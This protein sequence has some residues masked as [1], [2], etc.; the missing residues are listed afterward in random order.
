M[1]SALL[2]LGLGACDASPSSS[3]SPSPRA[4]TSAGPS[5]PD[6]SSAPGRTA[7]ARPTA[8]PLP[9]GTPALPAVPAVRSFHAAAGQ[10]WWPRPGTRVVAEDPAVEDEARL[11][12]AEIGATAVRG[13]ARDAREGDVRLVLSGPAEGAAREAYRLDSSGSRLVVTG[14][15]DT[16][17]FYGTRTAA[18]AL[19]ARG[20]LPSGVAEDRPD[21][22]QRGLM[23]DIARKHFSKEWLLDRVREMGDLKLN[24]LHLHISDDQGFRVESTSHPEVVSPRH[25]S[26]RDVSEIVAYA[27]ARHIT[28]IPEIDSPGHLGAVLR[29][30]PELQLRGNTGNR[31]EG[32]V[33]ISDPAA[34]RIIDD[35]F[36]EYAELFPGPYWHLGGDEYIALWSKNPEER[37]PQLAAWARER[38]GPDATVADAAT[39]WL[40]DRADVLRGLGRTVKAWNDGF[41]SSPLVSPHP[42]REVEYWTGREDGQR[43]PEEF[44]R[45]GWR[46]VNLNDEYLYY[47]LGEPN[48]FTYPT[49]ERI[50]REW[51]PA[52]LR[53]TTPVARSLSGPDRVLG[54]RL[55]VWCDRPGAQ[56]QAQVAQGIRMPLRALAQRVWDPEAPTLSWE[57]FTR[58]ADRV[59]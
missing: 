24:Q 13:T 52:V 9:P 47:V 53:G 15:T 12:A 40:N 6:G 56:T 50:Y 30:H 43:S 48:R 38:F 5:A 31:P 44:L 7:P 46:L 34:A 28:V 2:A 18:Q 8:A 16:G 35:L 39:A 29:A 23:V 3:G 11:F 14:G 10:G 45:E 1:L 42:G 32:T 37:Y 33:D 4:S 58:L 54:A 21:R 55:A 59:E 27:R 26:K 17:V 25:L 51:S 57:S 20:H 22:P 49:G 19:R 36:R 41:H